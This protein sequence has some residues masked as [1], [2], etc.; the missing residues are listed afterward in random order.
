MPQDQ[1]RSAQTATTTGLPPRRLRHAQKP[2][3]LLSGRRLVI[4]G[5]VVALLLLTAIVL[6]VMQALP[7]A[8]PG[9]AELPPGEQASGQAETALP[10]AADREAEE[11]PAMAG[12]ASPVSGAAEVIPTAADSLPADAAQ[13]PAKPGPSLVDAAQTPAKPGPSLVDAAQ[14]PAKPETSPSDAVPQQQDSPPP[15]PHSA[16]ERPLPQTEELTAAPAG[17]PQTDAGGSPSAPPRSNSTAVPR[18]IKHTVEKGDTLFSLSRRYYGN[19]QGWQRIARYNG[20]NPD[21]PLPIGKVLSIPAPK[22][23]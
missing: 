20:L 2:P 10:P 1:P 8:A 13:T 6:G 18:V 15:R 4:G 3:L 14:T 23:S 21:D 17:K 12:S 5:S 16:A 22:H 7:Q 9:V 11:R 19:N